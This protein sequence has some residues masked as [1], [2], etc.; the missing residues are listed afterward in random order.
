[1]PEIFQVVVE[2]ERQLDSAASLIIKCISKLEV[3]QYNF[4]CCIS[5]LVAAGIIFFLIAGT[6]LYFEFRIRIMWMTH[7]YFT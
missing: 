5:V 1:M 2:I 3:R 6:V 7:W 4:I